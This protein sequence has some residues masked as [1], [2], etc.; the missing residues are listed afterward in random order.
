MSKQTKSYL[1]TCHIEHLSMLT[2]IGL[3][4]LFIIFPEAVISFSD[5]WI[6]YAIHRLD[7]YFLTLC[8]S[9]VILALVLIISPIGNIRLGG[10]AQKPEFSLPTWIAMLFA[11]GM[12]SGLVFWGLAE[13]V[14]H[15]AFAPTL[16][17]TQ[18]H[19]RHTALALTYFH[20]G[21]HAW[22]IYTIVGLAMAWFCFN[23]KR[24][25]TI[26]ASFTTQTTWWGKA[27]D[28][29]A[30]LAVI[31]GVAGTLANSLILVE[32]GFERILGYNLDSLT[33]Q[34]SL[35]IVIAFIFTLSSALGIKRGIANLSRFNLILFMCLLFVL[36]SITSPTSVL[37]TVYQSTLTYLE[38]LPQISWHIAEDSKQW[39]DN[40]SI[41]YLIWWIAWAPFVGAFIAMI[42]KGRTIRQFLLLGILVPTITSI[43]WFSAFSVGLTKFNLFQPVLQAMNQHYTHGL[44]TFFSAIPMGQFLAALSLILLITFVITSADSAIYVS[45]MLLNHQDQ[46]QS[47]TKYAWSFV[48]LIISIAL[49]CRNDVELNR[50]IAILGALPYSLIM[51]LQIGNSIGSLIQK[52]RDP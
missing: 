24:T 7:T 16:V 12:G 33:F 34:I 48:L 2:C 43:V 28:I 8:S 36:I 5:T 40:W 11:A 50:H 3:V 52:K 27:I 41:N 35:L 21:L 13:P 9:I 23:Q 45:G 15:E 39:S 10:Q 18:A 1:R 4:L 19:P 49:V 17:D 20:W 32:T 14:Y 6:S 29:F 31:F 44:F 37:Q 30:V 25:M 26:S 47:Y 22:S 46:K 42:S 51:I 38:I